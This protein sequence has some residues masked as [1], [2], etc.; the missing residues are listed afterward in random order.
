[1]KKEN[2][3]VRIDGQQKQRIEKKCEAHGIGIS[4]LIRA[5]L[6]MYEEGKIRIEL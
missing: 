1:M 3:Q 4:T 5:L 2:I 6:K